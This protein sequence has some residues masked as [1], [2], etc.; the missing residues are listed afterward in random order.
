MTKRYFPTIESDDEST[1]L[2]GILDD[3]EFKC[4]FKVY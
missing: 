3:V 4:A 1:M 2:K